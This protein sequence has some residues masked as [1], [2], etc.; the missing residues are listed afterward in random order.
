MPD[1]HEKLDLYRRLADTRSRSTS[2]T[3]SRSRCSTASASSPPPAVALFELRRLRVLGGEAKAS[4]I[5]LDHGK[6][7]VWLYRPLTPKQAHVLLTKSGEPLEFLSGK[8]MG[9]RLRAAGKDAKDPEAFLGAGAAA[10][11]ATRR[12]GRRG[13]A[14]T[15]PP[16]PAPPPGRLNRA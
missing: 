10:A 11:R 15:T 3:T 12:G 9:L 6:L 14:V 4:E 5:R 2:W 16:R 7:E 13:R 8:E 1:E